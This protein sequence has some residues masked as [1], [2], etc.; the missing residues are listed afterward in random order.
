MLYLPNNRGFKLRVLISCILFGTR[1]SFCTCPT[2]RTGVSLR[3]KGENYQR[4]VD[5]ANTEIALH[6]CYTILI[7]VRNG[8]PVY[9]TTLTTSIKSSKY[10]SRLTYPNSLDAR[11][12][13]GPCQSLLSHWLFKT[14]VFVLLCTTGELFSRRAIVI[15]DVKQQC[16]DINDVDVEKDHDDHKVRPRAHTAFLQRDTLTGQGLPNWR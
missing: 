7:Q 8:Y 6:M 10:N 9:F 13:H 3:S 16:Y 2:Y 1:D 14:S 11:K 12:V 4:Y 15:V 5:L